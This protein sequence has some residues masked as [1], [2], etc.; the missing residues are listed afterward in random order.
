M[1]DKE[2]GRGEDK[3]DNS[4]L[5]TDLDLLKKFEY[6]S[7][8]LNEIASFYTKSA[9]RRYPLTFMLLVLFGVVAVSEGAKGVLE[10][11]GIF[12][13]HPVYLLLTGLVILIFTG[14]LYKKLNK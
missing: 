2:M 14:N 10:S 4:Y 13:G 6:L 7:N 1:K 9:V 5:G 11:L 8:Q 3:D 12:A